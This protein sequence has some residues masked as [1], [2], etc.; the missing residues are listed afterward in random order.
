MAMF[1]SL[2]NVSTPHVWLTIQRVNIT[3]LGHSPVCLNHI[4]DVTYPDVRVQNADITWYRCAYS[5]IHV[6][7]PTLHIH[8]T[9]PSALIVWDGALFI[10]EAV[11]FRHLIVEFHVPKQNNANDG[12]IVEHQHQQQRNVDHSWGREFQRNE[13]LLQPMYVLDQADDAR[14]AQ[15]TENCTSGSGPV[16]DGAGVDNGVVGF[17]KRTPIP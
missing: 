1:W 12:I 13:Q 14:H 6:V 10:L 9:I 16:Q 5:D 2:S 3:C 8:V 4:H 15:E 7:R 17:Q 11:I